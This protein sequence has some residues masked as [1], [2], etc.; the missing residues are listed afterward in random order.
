[1]A[2]TQELALRKGKIK[3]FSLIFRILLRKYYSTDMYGTVLT[4]KKIT[5]KAKT[6]QITEGRKV[7]QKLLEQVS[8]DQ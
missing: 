6:T 5:G 8:F 7:Y 3:D 1:M 2:K 4:S